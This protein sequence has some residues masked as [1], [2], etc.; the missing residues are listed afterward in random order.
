MD[1][2]SSTPAGEQAGPGSAATSTAP[3]AATT[4]AFARATA[5]PSQSQRNDNNIKETIESILVA[6][7]LAFIFR[8]F[9]VEAFVIPTGSMAPTLLGAHLRWDCA[10]CGYR[11]VTN[12]SPHK[13][14]DDG[15]PLIPNYTGPVP[16]RN[17]RGAPA[18]VP[19]THEVKCPNCGFDVPRTEA[20]D[21]P[22]HYGDRILVL[23]YLYLFEDPQRWDVAVF[24][25][26][27]DSPKY[28][29]NY[30]KR[31]VGRPNE[32]VVL[33]DGDVYVAPA[34]ATSLDEFQIQTKPK[35]VQ[36]AL[37]RVVYDN[38]HHPRGLTRRTGAWRQPWTVRQGSGW[39]LDAE[40]NLGA[41]DRIF[42]FENSTSGGTIVFDREANPANNPLSD[43]LAY[44]VEDEQRQGWVPAIVGDLKLQLDY[45]RAAGEGPLRLRLS[46]GDDTFI[47]EITP[48]G[49]KL[50]RTSG[51]SGETELAA[52]SVAFSGRAIR[53]EFQNVDHQVTLRVNDEVLLQTTPQQYQ[54]D[55]RA[56]LEQFRDRTNPPLPTAA[57]TAER[58]SCALS[59]VSLWRDVYYLNRERNQ[60]TRMWA[61]PTDFPENVIHLGPKEYF[62]LGDNSLMSLDA[63][64][65]NQDIELADL[66]VA[67]GR[68]PD[69]FMLGKAFFV[70]WPAGYKPVDSA[71]MPAIT[72]NF[73][74]MRFI[75]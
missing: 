39:Q 34:G 20:Q 9:I 40:A 37:W 50:L 24:K 2:R 11:Y 6:F 38:D 5:D 55:K 16:G 72:P 66:R 47:A 57:I 63:R 1:E 75:R 32:S 42:T 41:A 36:D 46:K 61:S 12:Y 58:Q 73:G 44:D 28:Q 15:N 67:S 7:I 30:I 18:L 13:Y 26:P 48:T 60:D 74:D 8:A 27:F 23:K 64:M 49:A 33:L 19:N 69:R 62:V 21:V 14:D 59:H 70:Y 35:H 22:V 71:P 65:W 54:P 25:S 56:L 43:W 10:D 52:V 51:D 45:T 29:Q 68:V 4:A 3:G 53:I 17:S 31:L